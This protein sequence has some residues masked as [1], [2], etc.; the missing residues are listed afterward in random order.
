MALFF[1]SEFPC[2]TTISERKPSAVAASA[3]LWPW[4]PRVAVTM[5]RASGWVR[6]SQCMK[7]M[8]PRTLNAPVGVWFSCLTHTVQPN[9]SASKGQAYCAVAGI[10]W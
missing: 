10:T 8:P 4:L 3:R 5:P 9:R 1:S 6:L 7:V 2:G